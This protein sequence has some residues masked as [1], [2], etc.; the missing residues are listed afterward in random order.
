MKKKI[1]EWLNGFEKKLTSY[2]KAKKEFPDIDEHIHHKGKIEADSI[3][4]MP[5]RTGDVVYLPTH[6]STKELKEQLQHNLGQ[7]LEVLQELHSIGSITISH[8]LK[9]RVELLRLSLK[10]LKETEKS[11]REII[12]KRERAA[13]ATL[14]YKMKRS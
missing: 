14:R 9:N 1:V 3:M 2:E 5:L 13:I 10:A 8:R 7:Q 12:E 6:F 4:Y 11:L